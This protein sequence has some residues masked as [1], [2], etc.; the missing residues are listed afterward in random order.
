MNIFAAIL[1]LVLHVA[2]G[3]SVNAA[4]DQARAAYA[5][6]GETTTVYIAP[7]DY[8]EELTIDVPGLR[9]INASP[10]PS[11]AVRNGGID[12]DSN[13]VRLTWYYGHGYQYASMHGQ[14]NYGG[15][16][17]RRWNASTLVTAPD[18]YAENIIFQNSFNLYV[19]T[20]EA[21][22]T[23][24]DISQARNDWTPNERPKR[25]MPVRPKDIGN[26]D[27]QTRF[28][29]ERASALSFTS[30]AKNCTLVNCRVVGRQ[31]ALYGDHGASV[32]ILGGVLAGAVDYIFGGLT[33]TVREAQLVAMVGAEKNDNCYISAGRAATPDNLAKLSPE[34]RDSVPK[35]EITD[36][37]MIFVDCQVRHATTD[38]LRNPGHAPVYLGRPWR[39]WGET[40]FVNTQAAPGVLSEERWSLG[41]TK[42][43]PAPF[44]KE[45]LSTPPLR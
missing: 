4:L 30:E 39:W 36:R 1:A 5:A 8:E 2:P 15:K 3:E 21:Q 40:V 7:G 19:S 32:T 45:D 20:A 9:L 23:L 16:R 14:F 29:R 13:A 12:L 44:V 33:L 34:S 37:G 22:D 38:E 27:V 6:S 31:D 28:Y 24:V 42:G 26:T 43:H 25:I 11:I 41:L 18:F 17:A 35:D 10:T